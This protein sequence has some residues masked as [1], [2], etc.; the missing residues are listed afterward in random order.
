M[1]IEGAWAAASLLHVPKK[2]IP[3]VFS[4][5][6][7]LLKEKGYLYITVKK[8]SGEILEKDLRYGDFEKFWSYFEEDELKKLLQEAKFKILDFDTIER[9]HVY[10]THDF[11]RVFCQKYN[12]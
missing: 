9:R 7:S 2:I 10:Q 12:I 3:V 4:K 6:H 5:I 1:A 11:F 8:G